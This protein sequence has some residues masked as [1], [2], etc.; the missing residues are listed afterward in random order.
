MSHA[1]LIDRIRK[2]KEL[3]ES[4]TDKD[5]TE[6]QTLLMQ[7]NQDTTN[8]AKVNTILKGFYPEQK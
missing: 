8:L 2:N 6:Y 4:R 1:E 3:L 7:V 5:S